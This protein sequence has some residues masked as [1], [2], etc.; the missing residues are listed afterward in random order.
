MA[1]AGRRRETLRETLE[2][3]SARARMLVV[4]AD[5]TGRSRRR[6][7]FRANRR[8]LWA[9]RCAVQQCGDGRAADCVR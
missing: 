3:S 5:V 7:S 6:E 1:L 8:A 4:E 9:R 2:A